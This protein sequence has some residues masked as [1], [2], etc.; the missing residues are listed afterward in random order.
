MYL[1]ESSLRDPPATHFHSH[2]DCH[3]E[4]HMLSSGAKKKSCRHFTLSSFILYGKYIHKCISTE[5]NMRLIPST[6][7]CLLIHSHIRVGTKQYVN[8]E[9][10][11]GTAIVGAHVHI[12]Y[13]CLTSH[14]T[15][16]F[17]SECSAHAHI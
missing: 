9:E 5:I 16:E 2:N 14:R 10:N 3:N 8:R 17:N 15:I 1:E 4:V 7:I 11:C 6:S 13:T 12:I